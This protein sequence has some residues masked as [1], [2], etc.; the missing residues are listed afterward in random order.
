MG[1]SGWQHRTSRLREDVG[2]GVCWTAMMSHPTGTAQQE[3]ESMET[4]FGGYVVGGGKLGLLSLSGAIL[5]VA[6][7]S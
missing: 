2:P 7:S 3:G 1:L 6:P 4:I 5:G